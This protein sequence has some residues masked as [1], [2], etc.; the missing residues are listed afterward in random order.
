MLKRD[1][2]TDRSRAPPAHLLVNGDDEIIRCSVLLLAE[3]LKHSARYRN[4]ME[5]CWTLDILFVGGCPALKQ[6]KFPMGIL[7]YVYF[8]PQQFE[9]SN[10]CRLQAKRERTR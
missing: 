4:A 7:L 9:L 2:A 3:E 1:S 6:K 10:S 5:I 8:D